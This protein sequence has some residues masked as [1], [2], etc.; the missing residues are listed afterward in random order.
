MH[1]RINNIA[2][3]IIKTTNAINVP[4]TATA[5]TLDSRS[6]WSAFISK[7]RETISVVLNDYLNVKQTDGVQIHIECRYMY[8]AGLIA[9]IKG[10]LLLITRQQYCN[11]GYTFLE[12]T[13]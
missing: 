11:A 6:K 7:K 10:Q 5:V 1:Y 9:K 4:P 8:P 12:Q 13:S 3:T 2:I